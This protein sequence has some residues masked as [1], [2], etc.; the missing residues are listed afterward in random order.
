MP[1]RK[2]KNEIGKPP[3]G[4][5]RAFI[6]M[7]KIRAQTFFTLSKICG[8]R[9]A[10]SLLG[11]IKRIKYMEFTVKNPEGKNLIE[12]QPELN[13]SDLPDNIYLKV[14]V[15]SKNN[16]VFLTSP[17]AEITGDRGSIFEV[18]QTVGL[19]KVAIL[20]KIRFNPSSEK[21]F[22]K[23]FTRAIIAA[24][25]VYEIQKIEAK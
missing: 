9:I 2:P 10:F 12:K 24:F 16:Q 21:S 15:D 5:I 20:E 13:I 6:Q 8:K 3:P 19:P 4:P 22:R 25:K 18:F 23:A 7:N 14:H 1:K 11:N 17:K